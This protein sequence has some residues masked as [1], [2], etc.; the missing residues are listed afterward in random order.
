VEKA[1]PVAEV[2]TARGSLRIVEPA[3]GVYYCRVD[4]SYSKE[5]YDRGFAAP[6]TRELPKHE[7]LSLF[8]DWWDLMGYDGAVRSAATEWVTEHRG[9]LQ[10][11]HIVMRSRLVAMGVNTAAMLLA[12]RGIHLTVSATLP[13]FES[14]LEAAIRARS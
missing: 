6:M 9:K 14:A 7:S 11:T 8:V 1:R 13:P 4:G 2:D 12:L 10:V 5:L 3:P